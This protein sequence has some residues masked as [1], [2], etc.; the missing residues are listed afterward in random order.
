V[1]AAELLAVAA[2][3]AGCIG[4]A[5]LLNGGLQAKRREQSRSSRGRAFGARVLAGV[6]RAV[7][8]SPP[9]RGVAPPG[10]LDARLAAAGDP[11][12]LGLREW[13]ALKGVCALL[14]WLAAATAGAGA[15]VALLLMLAG[16]VGGFLAP[17]LWLARRSRRRI[18]RAVAD[19]PDMLDLL[20]VM[21]EAGLPPARALATVAAEFR[22][23]LAREWRRVAAEVAL[24]V[25]QD[26]AVAALATRLP[27]EQMSAFADALTR[28]RRHGVPLGRAL[29]WQASRARHH[30]RQRVREQA[31][32]AGPTIQ[33]VVALLLVPSVLL[34]IAAGLIAEIDQAG[35]GFPGWSR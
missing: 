14:G 7:A 22:G 9:F 10:D 17:D 29:D 1:I 15:R 32:R 18:E 26:E 21:A 12:G 30:R 33:L 19:L 6:G 5:G 23:P 11:G 4:T 24:G 25:P 20:R 28:S 16:S 34:M 2:A 13:L 8:S 35:L 31:A 27:C 3:V